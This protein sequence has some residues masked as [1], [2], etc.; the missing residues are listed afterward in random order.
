LVPGK[1]KM[2]EKP[3][4]TFGVNEDFEGVFNAAGEQKIN[5]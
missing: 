1:A 4:F 5:F 2:P 3:E